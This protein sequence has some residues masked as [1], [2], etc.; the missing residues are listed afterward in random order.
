MPP[1]AGWSSD[2]PANIDKGVRELIDRGYR[3]ISLYPYTMRWPFVRR[4]LGQ[5]GIYKTTFIHVVRVAR[6]TGAAIYTS[7]AI[8]VS[9][10]ARLKKLGVLKNRLVYRW[11]G[12][13]TDLQALENGL[14]AARADMD[15]LKYADVCLLASSILYDRLCRIVPSY[16]HKLQ[17]W[18]T[19]VD[20]AF[21]LDLVEREPQSPLRWDVV[22]IGSDFKR[23]W[24]VPVALA[25]RGLKV[26]LVTDD[27][28]V[29]KL[30][31]SRDP[32]SGGDVELFYRVGFEK[33]ARLVLAGKCV[34]IATLPNIRFSGSTTVGVAAALSRPLV[35]DDVAEAPGYGLIPGRNCEIFERGNVESAYAAIQRILDD[36][37]HQQ[38]LAQNIGLLSD[39]L[40]LTRYATAVEGCLRSNWVKEDFKSLHD[41]SLTK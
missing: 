18:P 26:A 27:P 5:R 10:V 40:D 19:G 21:Y 39:E 29:R 1:P 38:Q 7:S 35:L 25:E 14:P 41:G 13:D 34:L 23:D 33:S 17:F 4:L 16:S 30:L 22:A 3:V 36:D 2:T 8:W 28:K 37:R 15:V 31:E 24:V 20:S 6:R 11:A 32:K 12:V 9:I